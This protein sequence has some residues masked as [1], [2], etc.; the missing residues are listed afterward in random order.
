MKKL[1]EIGLKSQYSTCPELKSWFKSFCA[2]ALMPV[3]NVTAMVEVLLDESDQPA[4]DTFY[5]KTQEFADYFVETWIEGSFDLL[6]WNHDHNSLRSNNHVEGHNLKVNK[7]LVTCGPNIWKLI[8]FIQVEESE[9]TTRFDKH[10]SG[11]LRERGR[12]V[13][14][15]ERDL[16]IA[17]LRLQFEKKEFTVRE[18]L[19]KLS[20]L[21]P[22]F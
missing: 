15:V 14:D 17:T 22:D 12:N 2:L 3:S 18:L 21:T 16:E 19:D 6:L 13:K 4:F 20:N 1:V 10:E 5:E 8:E 7:Q 9:Q 11:I